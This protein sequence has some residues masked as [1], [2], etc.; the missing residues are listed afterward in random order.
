M[1]PDKNLFL[2]C[3][4]FPIHLWNYP[5]V[6]CFKFCFFKG[7]EQFE[8]YR[9]QVM[10]PCEISHGL[11][12]V[13]IVAELDLL[14]SGCI[15][16]LMGFY[17]FCFTSSAPTERPDHGTVLSTGTPPRDWQRWQWTGKEPDSTWISALP[18]NPNPCGWVRIWLPKLW[19]GISNGL[20]SEFQNSCIPRKT[21]REY[22]LLQ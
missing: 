12:S 15:I 10:T 22:I 20:S 3:R 5:L 13:Y 11:S 19:R 7:D 4:V 6:A 1:A 18:F 21:S 14:H 2:R 17:I 9:C 16:F 8:C